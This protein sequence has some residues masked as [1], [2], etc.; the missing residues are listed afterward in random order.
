M[1]PGFFED[2]L[3]AE[4][5]LHRPYGAGEMIAF[6][7]A[8]NLYTLKFMKASEQLDQVQLQKSLREMNIGEWSRLV[9]VN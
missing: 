1:T 3:N 8:Y 4:N 9:L 7:F 6:N 2:Y 5:I